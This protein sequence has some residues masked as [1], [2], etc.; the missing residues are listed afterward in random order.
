MVVTETSQTL[1][2]A[3]APTE[4]ARLIGLSRTSLYRLCAAGELSLLK[5]GGRTLIRTADLAAYLDR[6]AADGR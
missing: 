4:A 2:L 1:P 5:V 6:L 3:V